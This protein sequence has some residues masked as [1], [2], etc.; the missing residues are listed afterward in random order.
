MEG[1][2]IGALLVIVVTVLV[3]LITL[4]FVVGWSLGSL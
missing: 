3:A 4:A 2:Q 1:R